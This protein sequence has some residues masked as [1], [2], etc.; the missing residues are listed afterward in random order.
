MKSAATAAHHGDNEAARAP[1]FVLAVAVLHV[2]PQQPR[3]LLVQAHRLFHHKRLAWTAVPLADD[4]HLARLCI[5]S[6]IAQQLPCHFLFG[7]QP[8]TTP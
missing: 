7:N 8:V 3:V 6:S 5:T 4:H 1:D 2:L